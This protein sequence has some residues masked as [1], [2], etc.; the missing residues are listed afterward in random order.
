[1]RHNGSPGQI[2]QQGSVFRDPKFLL[3][4]GRYKPKIFVILNKNPSDN[5]IHSVLT[6]SQ[7]NFYD[8]TPQRKERIKS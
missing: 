5:L 3:P 2:F 8:R 7:F 1:M 4:D 6:T